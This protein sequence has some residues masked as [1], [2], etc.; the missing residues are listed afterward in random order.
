MN[1]SKSEEGPEYPEDF[2]E[3]VLDIDEDP[4][5]SEAEEAWLKEDRE[6]YEWITE[7]DR[8]IL[9]VLMK[10]NLTLTPAVIADNIDRSRAGVSRRLN[11]L[12]AGGLVEKEAR[13]KY[14][15]S[16]L[17]AGYLMQGLPR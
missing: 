11:A 12:N 13:G 10:S 7:T 2:E 8:E 4:D 3:V 17:G 15:I 5:F 14:S 1:N 6:D 16:K 9:S